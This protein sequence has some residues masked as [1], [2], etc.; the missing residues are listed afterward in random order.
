MLLDDSS[1]G[2]RNSIGELR[3]SKLVTDPKQEEKRALAPA[4]VGLWSNWKEEFVQKMLDY[5][6]NAGP[7]MA[8]LQSIIQRT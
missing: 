4:A 5:I 8:S 6:R 1:A 3:W 2:A 7:S